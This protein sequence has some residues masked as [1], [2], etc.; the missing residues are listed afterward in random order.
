MFQLKEK[1]S[2]R[3]FAAFFIVAV[4]PIVLMG[5]G[6]YRAAERTLID[7]AYMHIQTIAQDRTNKLHSWYEER[8]GDIRV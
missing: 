5:I 3:F 2:H 1:I 4:I 6:L 7:S 8:L